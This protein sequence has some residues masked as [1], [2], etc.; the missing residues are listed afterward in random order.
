MQRQLLQRLLHYCS[1]QSQQLAATT[2]ATVAATIAETVAATN[3]LIFVARLIQRISRS[4]ASPVTGNQLRDYIFC[5]V[6]HGAVFGRVGGTAQTLGLVT[7]TLE[8]YFK[9]VKIISL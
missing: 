7:I 9:S 1:Y 3:L 6:V 2:A 4:V 8:R 5:S